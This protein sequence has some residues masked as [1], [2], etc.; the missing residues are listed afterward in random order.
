MGE[1]RDKS[2]KRGGEEKRGPRGEG[3]DKGYKGVENGDN[4]NKNVD[5]GKIKINCTNTT[6]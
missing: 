1:E 2:S 3:Y 6:Q 4:K 5:P